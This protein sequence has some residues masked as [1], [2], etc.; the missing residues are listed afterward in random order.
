M[1]DINLYTMILIISIV[2]LLLRLIPTK[3]DLSLISNIK[4][5][6]DIFIPNI[7]QNLPDLS[8]NFTTRYKDDT[9]K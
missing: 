1:L 4:R 2:E 5:L 9:H 8:D 3:K 7:K 6:V